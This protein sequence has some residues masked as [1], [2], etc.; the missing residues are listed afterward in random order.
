MI[1]QG[2]VNLK[3][4]AVDSSLPAMQAWRKLPEGVLAEVIYGKLYVL[5]TPTTY[6]AEVTGQIFYE[7]M[8]YLRQAKKGRVFGTRVSVF[9]NDR[10]DVVIPDIVYVSNERQGIVRK[11][12]IYGTP[13][14]HIEVLSPSN[15]RHDLVLKRALYEQA[16]VREYWIIDPETKNAQGYLLKDGRYGDPLLTNSEIYIRI[17]NKLIPF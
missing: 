13:D 16:A 14:L 12:A 7:L 11:S 4:W 10:D 2:R 6:H 17:L 5:G 15:S 8:N 3:N 9:L 1:Q